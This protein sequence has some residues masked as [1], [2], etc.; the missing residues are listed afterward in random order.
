MPPLSTPRRFAG[1]GR[2]LGLAVAVTALALPAAAQRTVTLRMNAST[3]PDTLKTTQAL[4]G[5]QLRGCLD[6]CTGDQS[7]LPGGQIIAWNAN[8]TLLPQ[9]VGG[10]YWQVQFQIPDNNLLNFK[11]YFDQSDRA[12]ANG[13]SGIGGW[14]DGDNLTIP[15]G[16]G[17]VALDLHYFNRTGGNQ[18]YDWRPFVANGDSIAVWFR[19]YMK[20]QDA[21]TRGYTND[22]ANLRVSLRGNFGVPGTDNPGSTG[23]VGA[24]G[25]IL[26][27]GSTAGAPE[28]RL[29]R[30][31]TN[32]AQPG[33]DIFSGLVK[34]P[35]SSAG[36]RQT[37]KFYFEDSDV[38]GDAGY[39]GGATLP[40]DRTFT[41]PAAGSDTTLYI[42]NFSDS[43]AG[44]PAAQITSATTFAVDVRPLS[45]AGIFQVADDAIQV[46]GGFNGWDCPADNNDDCAL[47]R[48]PSSFNY[49]RQIPVT[50]PA[51]TMWA[52]KY[53]VDFT[54]ALANPDFGY[55]E[56]L[57]YGGGNR[58]YTTNGNNTQEIGTQFF[59]GIRADNVIAAGTTINVGFQVDMRPALAFAPRAF[60]P[61]TD[62]VTIFFQDPIWNIT[63]GRAPAANTPVP[64]FVLTDPDGD[65]IYTGSIP[66]KG[67]TYNG[68]GYQAAFGNTADGYY[69]EGEGGFEGG[70]RRYRYVLNRTAASYQFPKDTFR[71]NTTGNPL[72]WEINP[73]GP[74]QPGDPRIKNSRPNGF[75]D[76]GTTVA[77]E[78]GPGREGTLA[79]SALAPNPTT[80]I[81]RM[82]VRTAEGEALTVRVY[83]V[84]GRMV[85][86]VTEGAL[87]SGEQ[88]LEV[89]TQGL[90][91]GIYVVRATA[92]TSV[93]TRRLT[94]IR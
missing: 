66:V 88:R 30:E 10:D 38:T 23:G 47:G 17:P 64:N 65:G 83:D 40:N 82:T 49:T 80:G 29:T 33:Y 35:A 15:A 92:G 43:P 57:D 6:G 2:W 70:R 55:E 25:Q 76:D 81:A 27:W 26:D 22:D 68:I 24:G 42:K 14:E 60:N 34:Y 5:A 67:P 58:F 84:M 89:N 21:Q 48:I 45:D 11:F 62:Q 94:V 7:A 46:R 52:Y 87:A 93:A 75:V 31:S 77:N 61:A 32:N 54:P 85:Q 8:T 4:A 16:T 9:N 59:N 73:T 79:I 13:G 90:A 39:E 1:A 37:Y 50:S 18:A 72:P 56:P 86:S 19:V 74:F 71:P 44:V 36:K 69:T 20:S 53:F 41:I 3:M 51:G 78:D 63:Q 91:A 28:A 12:V